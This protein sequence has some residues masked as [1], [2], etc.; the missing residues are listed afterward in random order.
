MSPFRALASK[1]TFL[2]FSYLSVV[3]FVLLPAGYHIKS[4][5]GQSTLRKHHCLTAYFRRFHG[6]DS[7][8]CTKN[9]ATKE[10]RRADFHTGTG[11]ELHTL[12][13]YELLVAPFAVVAVGHCFAVDCPLNDACLPFILLGS[14]VLR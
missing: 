12:G 13:G 5:F 9:D 10:F 7:L 2:Y 8:H 4:Q 14:D 1:R 6:H 11:Q 3:R